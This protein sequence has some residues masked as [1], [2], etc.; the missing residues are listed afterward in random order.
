MR[1]GAAASSLPLAEP[2]A[3]AAALE[4]RRPLLVMTDYDG[5]L[6]PIRDTPAA[7]RPTPALLTLLARLSRQH[8]LVLAVVSG[9]DLTDL[10]KM[11]PLSGL[12]L[13]GSH[14]AAYCC[15]DGRLF[16]DPAAVWSAP[17]LPRV[18]AMAERCVGGAAGF[19]IERKQAAVALHYRL[20]EGRTATRVVEAFLTAV[21][22]LLVRYHL[23]VVC[24][25]KVVEVRPRGVHKGQVVMRLKRWHSDCF[26]VYLGDDTTDE[27]AFQ[28]VTHQGMGVFVGP[29]CRL[30]AACWRLEGPAAVQALLQQLAD[31]N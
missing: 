20:A 22:P 8:G 15:P 23:Q 18:A 10:R 5:T 19:L 29:A 24:G 31:G 9:R 21:Q 16:L 12:Y 3:L 25:K 17:V 2:A 26:P 14:G 1:S 28:A 4:Q 27:D 11:L 7:A 30:T 6:V 13:V